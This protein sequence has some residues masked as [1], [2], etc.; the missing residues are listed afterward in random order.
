M[1]NTNPLFPGLRNGNSKL[2]KH[3]LSI[4]TSDFTKFG[5]DLSKEDSRTMC[6]VN[7]PT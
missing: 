5:E 1:P 7:F 2:D 3:G 4:E 6:K